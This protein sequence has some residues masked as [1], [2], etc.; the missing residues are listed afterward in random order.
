M[1][2]EDKRQQLDTIVSQMTANREN[3]D[4]IQFVVND[5][6]NRHSTEE[7][8][9]SFLEK[10]EKVLDALFGGGK[11]GEAIGSGIAKTKIGRKIIGAP[12]I[13]EEEEKGKFIKTPSIREI[14]GSALQSAALFTPIGT[15][16]KG[17]TGG[18]RALGLIK[19]AS[20]LGKISSGVLAGELFDIASNLQQGKV[21]K[22][23]L[24]PGIGALIGGAIPSAEIAKNVLVRF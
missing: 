6:K 22:E 21:G 14:T 18:V 12:D 16:A 3:D 2:A 11:V 19:G 5:F 4:A 15:V 8:E 17:I 9:T 23:V 10:T 20:A 13:L 1:L 24:T 7:P